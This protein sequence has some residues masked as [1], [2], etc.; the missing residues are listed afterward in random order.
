MSI[1]KDLGVPA[2]KAGGM[3]TVDIQ[4]YVLIPK[5]A[6]PSL[7]EKSQNFDFNDQWSLSNGQ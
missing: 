4:T 6:G 3:P 1:L 2:F 7:K 5:P